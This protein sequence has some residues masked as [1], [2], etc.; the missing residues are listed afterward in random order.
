MGRRMIWMDAPGEHKDPAAILMLATS[1]RL[2]AYDLAV[3]DEELRGALVGAAD[4]REQAGEL[5]ARNQAQSAA[6]RTGQHGPV[7]IVFFSDAT[8]ILQ[9]ENRA[10]KHLFG[11]P[12]A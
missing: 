4:Y 8:G 7:G 3:I 1:E 2:S 6:F 5:L 11:D 10:G 12:L 9:H